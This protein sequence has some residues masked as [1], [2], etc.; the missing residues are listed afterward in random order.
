VRTLLTLFICSCLGVNVIAQNGDLPYQPG[1]V[2]AGLGMA[3][4][5][6]SN[7]WAT[8]HNPGL[9]PWT[10]EI[11]FGVGVENRFLLSELS[12]QGLASIVP[13]K[14]SAF[15]LSFASHGYNLYRRSRV[16]L[17]Y[18]LKL[19]DLIA[20]GIGL[21]YDALSIGNNYGKTGALTGSLGFS[22]KVT[23]DLM[24]AASLFNPFQSKLTE[25]ERI[26]SLLAIGCNY[27]FS[28]KVKFLLEV[29]KDIN[30]KPALKMGIDFH[31][32]E[33]LYIRAGVRTGPQSYTFGVGLEFDAL[34][35]DLSSWVHPVLGISP[36]MS[37]QY[38]L[39]KPS[40]SIDV[41]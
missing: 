28:E 17:S 10:E 29:Q 2:S 36:M 6:H 23:E 22:V 11:S 34:T 9:L 13:A 3:Q 24:I 16:G 21:S 38:T 32:V 1:A 31:P 8:H 5:A 35:I 25:T 33:I 27:R 12:S 19:N 7:V 18:G 41:K 40:K 26:P 30:Q 4:V 14:N 15:G 39:G 37:A 20:L